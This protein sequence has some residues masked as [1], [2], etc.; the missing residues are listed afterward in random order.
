MDLTG[1]LIDHLAAFPEGDLDA[2]LTQM[3]KGHLLDLFGAML[4]ASTYP[5]AEILFQFAE[6]EGGSPRASLVGNRVKTSVATAALINGTLGYYCDVEPHHPEAVAHPMATVVPAALAVAESA[7]STGVQ[8]LAAC[9]LG[10]EVACR[11]SLALDPRALYGRGFHPT[12]ISGALGAAVAAGYL[13]GLNR[14]AWRSTLGLASL[15]ASGLLAWSED[16]TEQSRPFNPGIS[17]R[18]GATAALL[19]ALGFGGP[20]HPLEGNSNIFRAFSGTARTEYLTQNLKPYL[21]VTGLATK[22][23]ACC[24]FLHPGLDALLAIMQER[25]LT[26]EDIESIEIFFPRAGASIIDDNPLRS[27]SAQYVLATAAK[28]GK[29]TVDH[30]LTDHRRDPEIRRLSSHIRLVHDTELD[31]LY[32]QRYATII[33]V[34]DRKGSPTRRRIDVAKGYPEAPLSDRELLDKYYSNATRAYDETTATRIREMILSIESVGNM[35][36]LGDA[37]R[38]IAA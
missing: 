35:T 1:I 7:E 15:Q 26:I 37:L 30:I 11:L 13:L 32:P 5:A 19:G 10:I 38:G 33:V 23:Y 12:A 24:A 3:T 34:H 21:G 9:I 31:A 16:P 17:A 29:V 14:P 4:A 18:N 28:Y 22:Q 6:L 25:S 36:I 20:P 8:F 27:H 2:A